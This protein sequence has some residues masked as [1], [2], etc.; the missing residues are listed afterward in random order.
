MREM[1][2]PKTGKKN[3]LNLIHIDIIYFV[4]KKKL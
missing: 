4:G 1:N 3:C 2:A